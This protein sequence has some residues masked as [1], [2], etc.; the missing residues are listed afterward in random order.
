MVK[1]GVVLVDYVVSAILIICWRVLQFFSVFAYPT[2]VLLP[3][4]LR[5]K[6]LHAVAYSKLHLADFMFLNFTTESFL[7]FYVPNRKLLSSYFNS[8]FIYVL[9]V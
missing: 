4:T 3:V 2:Q 5:I 1:V 8:K 7:F 6:V 9:S